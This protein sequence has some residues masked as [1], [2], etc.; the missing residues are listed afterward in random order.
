MVL[1]VLIG[2]AHDGI[3]KWG[4]KYISVRHRGYRKKRQKVPR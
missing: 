3:R 4:C 2:K 1:W